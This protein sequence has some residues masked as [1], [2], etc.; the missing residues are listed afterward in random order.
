MLVD[1]VRAQPDEL[2]SSFGELWLEFR[3]GAQ[4]SG[5]TAT[6]ISFI[7]RHLADWTLHWSEIFRVR[8]QN[9]PLMIMVSTGRR[10]Q[11]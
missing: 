8:E 7:S 1:G 2:H 4:F 11:K 5:A 3:E 10:L 6:S 9:N